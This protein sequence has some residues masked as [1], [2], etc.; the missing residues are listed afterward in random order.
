MIIILHNAIRYSQ[1]DC[2]SQF[3]MMDEPVW[4]DDQ[5]GM[6]KSPDSL[7]A[8]FCWFPNYTIIS[9][10]SFGSFQG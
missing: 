10:E 8:G 2:K 3:G 1:D 6:S 9:S 4:C 5:F 7:R